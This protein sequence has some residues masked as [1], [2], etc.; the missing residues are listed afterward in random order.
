M[1]GTSRRTEKDIENAIDDQMLDI[2]AKPALLGNNLGAGAL[3]ESFE[4][5]ESEEDLNADEMSILK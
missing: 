2:F 5:V 1:T 4:P 3:N